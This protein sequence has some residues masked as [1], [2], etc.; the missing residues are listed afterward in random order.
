MRWGI[1]ILIFLAVIGGFIAGRHTC[2]DPP[3]ITQTDTLITYKTDTI[4]KEKVVPKYIYR[5]KTDTLLYTLNDT[6]IIPVPVP[7]NKYTFT[8]DSL[9]FIEATG[10]KVQL[11]KIKITQP[12]QLIT[13]TEYISVPQRKRW[14][15][16]V[17]AGW[18]ITVNDGRLSTAP[19]LGIG[20]QYNILQF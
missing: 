12:T 19:Y 16:G 6:I 8:D 1:L 20:L 11:D 2:D 18:G 17:T 15:L 3:I 9:Y 13:V 14:G 5:Y 4:V 7:I 10:Y